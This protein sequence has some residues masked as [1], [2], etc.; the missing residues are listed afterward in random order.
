MARTPTHPPP[1]W[2][3]ILRPTRLWAALAAAAFFIAPRF[4]RLQP[5]LQGRWADGAASGPFTM[6]LRLYWP[7]PE[8]LAGI[9]VPPGVKLAQ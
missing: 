8:I 3:F 6:S 4:A 7:K 5:H 9:W 2:P 1:L